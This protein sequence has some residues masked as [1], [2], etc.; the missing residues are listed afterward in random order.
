MPQLTRT[1]ALHFLEQ[2]RSAR[3]A[4][5]RDAEQFVEVVHAVERLG[6]YLDQVD[7]ETGSLGL[8]RY[9]F[10]IAKIVEYSPLASENPP[11]QRAFCSIYE[12]VREARNDAIHQGAF[13]RHLATNSLK[14][15]IVLEDA[16]RAVAIAEGS[17]MDTIDVYMVKN[18]ICAHLWQP[19]SY[20]R[21]AMLENSFS[22]LP[23]FD[24]TSKAWKLVSD[25]EVAK[26]LDS[27]DR[28]KGLSTF[29][30]DA[31]RGDGGPK[32]ELIPTKHYIVTDCKSSV[33]R[34]C[35][36][37]PAVIVH[38]KEVGL[39]LGIVTPFDLM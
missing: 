31:V 29:L 35:S 26:F 25:Y 30:E 21:L 2:V 36:G 12:S 6:T 23:L 5:L 22:Y 4:V 16:L 28:R 15:A 19:I 39:A 18:P 24:Q 27:V 13:A 10:R 32:I 38:D 1:T 9:G 20:I 3:E 17:P 37:Y 33:L 34:D 7:G 14:L 11:W 8:Y